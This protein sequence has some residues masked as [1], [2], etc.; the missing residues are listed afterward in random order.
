MTWHA[1]PL[2]SWDTETTGVNVETARIVTSALIHCTPGGECTTRTWVANPGITIPEEAAKIHGYDTARAQADGRPAAEVVEEIAEELTAALAAGTP[3]VA[4]NARFDFSVLDRELRRYGLPTLGERVGSETAPGPV[5][6]PL[7]IDKQVD[8]Y[9]KGSRKLEALAAHY[10]VTLAAAHTADADALAAV[11]VA[12]ALAEKY[13]Q[14]QVEPAELYE[15][16]IKWAA[17]QAASFQAYKRRTDPTAEVEGAWPLVP[18]REPAPAPDQPIRGDAVE[19]WLKQQ[20]DRHLDDYGRNPEWYALDDLLDTYR[21]HADT[22]T[23]LNEHI[24]EGRIASEC[25][26][27]DDASARINAKGNES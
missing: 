16:Q 5:I 3:L 12:V 17:D 15:W 7:I 2:A 6:D 23:P 13:P 8:K 26:C 19:A 24:C 4:M 1:R 9:R 11:Q 18:Y 21:L 22:R 14:L 27:P 25:D 10:G 20:R